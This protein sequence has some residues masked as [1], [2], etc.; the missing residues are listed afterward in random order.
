MY[1]YLS[2]HPFWKDVSCQLLLTPSLGSPR[3]STLLHHFLKLDPHRHWK[4]PVLSNIYR[5]PRPKAA[6]LKCQSQWSTDGDIL[7]H[8]WFWSLGYV[9]HPF[10]TGVVSHQNGWPLHIARCLDP[11][12]Q[13]YT[14]PRIK[15]M[16]FHNGGTPKSSIL[17]HVHWIFPYKP[18][19]YWGTTMTMET[20]KWLVTCFPS[21]SMNPPWWFPPS[22]EGHVEVWALCCHKGHSVALDDRSFFIAGFRVQDF[23]RRNLA[24]Q[25]FVC[26]Y[27]RN[28]M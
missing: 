8:W 28:A 15:Y 9:A 22:I 11:H 7:W 27:V 21:H 17:E 20:G 18:S 26:T 25:L 12:W 10:C 14:S 3:F 19:S 1:L 16:G 24:W 5:A 6:I 4:S 13:V 2:I 23:H